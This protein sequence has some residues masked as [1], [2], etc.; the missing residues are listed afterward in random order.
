VNKI[1]YFSSYT[2]IHSDNQAIKAVKAAISSPRNPSLPVLECEFPP[3]KALNKLGDG[4][5]R[6]ATEAEQVREINSTTSSM[7]FWLAGSE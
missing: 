3:L 2:E 1:Q 7:H 6:S 4:S 5:L